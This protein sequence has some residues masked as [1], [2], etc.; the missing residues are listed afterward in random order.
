VSASAVR[1]VTPFVETPKG[2]T[3][4]ATSGNSS[5]YQVELA[6]SSMPGQQYSTAPCVVD[7]HGTHFE[8]GY[9]YAAL[10][11]TQTADTFRSFLTSIYPSS[12]DQE[13]I[14]KFADFCWDSWLSKNTP[15]RFLDELA[16][17]QAYYAAVGH[18]D[19]SGNYSLANATAYEVS[20]RFFTLAN[21]PA[22]T[23]NIISMLEQEL[24][25]GWPQ[26]L[27]TV[28][29]DIIKLLEKWHHSC[30]A[31]GVWG[32]RTQDS[33]LY[34]SRNLDYASD[35][36][37]NAHKLIQVFNIDDPK[38]GGVPPGGVYA[39]IGF[40][41]GPGA[42]AGMS[43]VGITTSEMNLDN[44]VVT[45]SGVPFPLRL[46]Y[47]LEEA[48]NLESAMTVWN[49]T[50]NTN[51]F[52]FLIG[53][54]PDAL[55]YKASPS[56]AINGA[57]ALETIMDFTAQ[58]PANSSIERAATFY[59]KGNACQSWTNQTGEVHIGS[60]L[61]EAVWRTNHGFNPRVMA[62]QEPLFN[63]TVF[64]YNIMHD[65]FENLA[66]EGTLIDD[67]VAI[68]IV[69]TLGTK[70]VDY[71]T[72]DQDFGHADNIMSI[73]YAPGPRTP[74]AP[75]SAGHMYIAWESGGGSSWRPAACSPYMMF[76]LAA[77]L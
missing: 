56:P 52:N 5:L 62:T 36:G 24:E 31:Y 68:G 61:P 65:L 12:Q 16:G 21:M 59:C 53:S 40:A 73:A 10:L 25:Q 28:I 72:C 6:S 39:S 47:V 66:A 34:S 15:Q 30:D 70:G 18:P 14:M 27:K 22:D 74:N 77:W 17:M 51:S 60:P 43:E 35:T 33:L 58:F 64:R 54:A 13:L 19:T 23:V 67:H 11:H 57:F 3:H 7:L 2:Y 49:A 9:D 44:S 50:N 76:D 46:R 48:T 37:I 45:F 69:A 38:Y 71:F 42:L 41:F 55:K 1:M 4:L 63:N 8:I 20:R 75:S 29:N 26:W 32:S